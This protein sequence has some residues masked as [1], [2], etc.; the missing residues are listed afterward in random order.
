MPQPAPAHKVT[1]LKASRKNREVYLIED[2]GTGNSVVLKLYTSGRH[3][4][5]ECRVLSLCRD[6]P[7]FVQVLDCHAGEDFSYLVMEYVE[8]ET[9]ASILAKR[10]PMRPR[11]VIALAVDVL[12]GLK[13]LHERGFVHGDL[14]GRNIIV[15]NL[16]EAQ[17]KIVDLQHAAEIDPYKGKAKA[18]RITASNHVMFPPEGRKGLIDPRY[19]LYGVGYMC[20]CL[21]TGTKWDTDPSEP[22]AKLD[23]RPVARRVWR[24]VQ[25]AMQKDPKLRYRSAAEMIEALR[26]L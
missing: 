12:L 4:L 25:K 6:D 19:D 24:I 10:E 16:E 8:G 1:Q 9:V 13:A 23:R 2:E 14:Q 20:A 22:F 3:A 21:L 5:H 15:T 26:S 18:V 17:T 7:H 11:L